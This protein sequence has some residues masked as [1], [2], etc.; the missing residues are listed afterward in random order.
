MD[1]DVSLSALLSTHSVAFLSYIYVSLC[2]FLCTTTIKPMGVCYKQCQLPITIANGKTIAT[3]TPKCNLRTKVSMHL[4]LECYIETYLRGHEGLVLPV[5]AP[6]PMQPS[7]NKAKACAKRE[8]GQN[9]PHVC[10]LYTRV[11]FTWISESFFLSFSFNY[12][13]ARIPPAPFHGISGPVMTTRE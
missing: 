12:P 9:S 6:E 4:S 5:V 13:A 10:V 2:F 3:N 1:G 11:H 8:K 7:I